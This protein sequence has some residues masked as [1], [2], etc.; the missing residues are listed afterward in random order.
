MKEEIYEFVR[1]QGMAVVATVTKSGLP[2]AALVAIAVNR[3]LELVFDTVRTSRK[4]ANLEANPAV[5]IVVGFESQVEVTLQY[6]GI[7]DE[8]YGDEMN[9]YREMYF[10]RWPDGRAR[11]SWPDIVH[12]RVRPSWVRFSDFNRKTDAIRE[13]RF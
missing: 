4:Y 11:L 3:D 5:A 1:A 8:P 13:M 10:D 9:R 6:E 12:I 2:E 7:A